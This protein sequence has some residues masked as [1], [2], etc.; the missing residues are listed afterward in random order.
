MVSIEVKTSERYKIQIEHGLLAECG[1]AIR[2]IANPDKKLGVTIAIITDDIVDKLYSEQLI[3]TL[4]ENGLKTRKFVFPNGETSKCTETLNEIYAFLAENNIT[5]TDTLIALGG[6]VVGDI[7]GYAAATWLRGVKYIQ[8]PTTLLAQIDSSVGGKTAINTPAGKNLVGAFKQPSLV[9]CDPATLNTLPLNVLSDGMAEAI[10]YGMIKDKTLFDKISF[11]DVTNILPII[12]SVIVRC[13]EIKRDIVEADEFE[14]G[15]RMLLN[16]GHTFGHAIEKMSDFTVPHGSAVAIGMILIT[17]RYA[18]KLT[19][20]LKHCI[21][22]YRLPL[23][24]HFPIHE[25]LELCAKDK[26]RNGDKI[27]FIVCPEIG[28]AEIRTVSMEDFYVECN[29]S[30]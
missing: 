15:D 5:R 12:E 1:G 24:T 6:G 8:I 23:G 22:N 18:E 4:T 2:R 27:N 28:T 26:K 25:L 13:V 14:N 11:F 30:N 17:E 29:V 20:R 16:F 10:K 21:I 3:K 9:I 19:K 7:T